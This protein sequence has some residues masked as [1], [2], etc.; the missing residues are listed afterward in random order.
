MQ[1]SAPSM[2]AEPTGPVAPVMSMLPVQPRPAQDSA[3]ISVENIVT[4]QRGD[5]LWKLAQKTLGRGSRYPELLAVNPRIANPNQIR[6]G[7]QLNLPVV[8]ASGVPDRSAQTNAATIITVRKGDTLWKLAKSNLGRS[9]AWP[10]L[11]SAN[12]SLRDPNRIYQGQELVLPAACTSA[13]GNSTP[14]AS[15]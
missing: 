2:P 5:S 14:R 11:A 9:S 12:P 1:P 6:S 10:C 13:S 15:P 8:D 4:V 7:A 3:G